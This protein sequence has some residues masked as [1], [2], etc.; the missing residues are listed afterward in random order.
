MTELDEQEPTTP[1]TATG[2]ADPVRIAGWFRANR[3]RLEILAIGATAIGGIVCMAATIL[4]V[5]FVGR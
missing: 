5:I 1:P 3:A 2:T 4:I